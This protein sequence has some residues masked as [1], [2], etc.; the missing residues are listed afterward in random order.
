MNTDSGEV[1]IHFLDYWRVLRVRMPLI[2]L[3]FLLVVITASV[4][5][6]LM[7]RQYGSTVTMQFRQQDA[8][9]VI[10][11]NGGVQGMDPRFISTQFE[12]IQR[13]EMLYPV[14]DSL[15]LMQRWGMPSKELTY[16]RLL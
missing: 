14:I 16:R 3:I 1:K 12:I 7:P 11:N 8:S 10:F 9:M 5:T 4:I 15:Q 13:K 2:I 6:Y